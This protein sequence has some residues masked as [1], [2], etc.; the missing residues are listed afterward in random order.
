MTGR[1]RGQT[2][3]RM[4]E[5]VNQPIPHQEMV[6]WIVLE[7]TGR[8]DYKG[9]DEPQAFRAGDTVL[10]PAALKEGRVETT[11]PGRWLEVTVP[12]AS[13]LADYPH[14]PASGPREEEGPQAGFVQLDL[15][16]S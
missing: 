10:L 16:D 2:G 11:S 8:V 7:G 15:P 9:A 12:I 6:V 13:S 5:G 14:P 1:G 4:A 3:V